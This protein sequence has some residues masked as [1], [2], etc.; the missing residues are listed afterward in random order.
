MN[1]FDDQLARYVIESD[2]DKA[3][4]IRTCEAMIH[5]RQEG[6]IFS[7]AIAEFALMKRRVTTR[8]EN[9]IHIHIQELKH[10]AILYTDYTSLLDILLA[11]DRDVEFDDSV[12]SIINIFRWK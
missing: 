8:A 3:K 2:E 9:D 12:N 7:L 5:A 11:F 4:F 6:K 1:L 10:N